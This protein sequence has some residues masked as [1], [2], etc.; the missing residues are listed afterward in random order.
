[1]TRKLV[2]EKDTILRTIQFLEHGPNLIKAS[3]TLMENAYKLK[4]N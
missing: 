3:K 4:I 2:F 1:M